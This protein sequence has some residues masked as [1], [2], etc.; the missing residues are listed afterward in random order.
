MAK[1]ADTVFIKKKRIDLE[2]KNFLKNRLDFG[3]GD[4]FVT[5]AMWKMK[6]VRRRLRKW[7]SSTRDI[8]FVVINA[9]IS[10]FVKC[11]SLGVKCNKEGGIFS[12]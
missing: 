11:M 5:D 7:R 4:F 9:Q 1:L 3:L 6:D 2:I 10:L 8:L 12:V